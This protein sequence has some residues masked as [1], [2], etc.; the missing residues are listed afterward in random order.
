MRIKIAA[1]LLILT[2]LGTSFIG[3]KDE[4]EEGNLELVSSTLNAFS[5]KQ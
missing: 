1:V 3:C 4:E 5:V 2:V